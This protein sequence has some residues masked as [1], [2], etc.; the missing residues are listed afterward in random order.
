MKK[1]LPYV[2]MLFLA[3][4]SSLGT[5]EQQSIYSG[6]KYNFRAIQQPFIKNK[7]ILP[8][9]TTLGPIVS[10]YALFDFPFSF[11]VD[12]LLLPQKAW[13]QLQEDTGQK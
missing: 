13:L 6:T 11:V 2:L 10:T 5:I 1:H 9:Y 3:G 4:C 7:P 8:P 12:S